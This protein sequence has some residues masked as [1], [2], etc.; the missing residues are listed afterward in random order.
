MGL[1][2]L[3]SGGKVM[4]FQV[5]AY[6]SG[7]DLIS[8]SGTGFYACFVKG[9]YLLLLLLLVLN[10]FFCQ[11]VFNFACLELMLILGNASYEF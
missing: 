2:L 7:F 10:N 5:E 9:V 3:W 4:G 11:I 8:F 1:V 6:V